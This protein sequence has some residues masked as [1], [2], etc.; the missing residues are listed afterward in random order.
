MSFATPEEWDLPSDADMLRWIAANQVALVPVPY[1]GW[2]VI[3]G[4]N[5]TETLKENRVVGR[6]K[7]PHEALEMAMKERP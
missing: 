4:Y 5:L 3:V 7:T 2:N 1:L 6:G